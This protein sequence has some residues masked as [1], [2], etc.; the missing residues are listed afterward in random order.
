MLYSY[1]KDDNIQ[2]GVF[3]GLFK[4][5]TSVF[6]FI[7]LISVLS[8]N[9]YC[10][11]N[12]V[13]EDKTLSPY[14]LVEGG[15]GEEFPL[16]DTNV[17]VNINGIIAEIYVTQTYENN[18][19]EAVNATYVFPASTKVSVHGMKMTI[20]DKVVRAKI[21]E[22]EIAKKE[23]EA[24]KNEGKS[25]SLLEEQ[26][27]NVFTMNVANIMPKDV[28]N[29]ELHYTE[30]ITPSDG[31]Y[32]FVYPTVVG[33]RYSNKSAGSGNDWVQSPYIKNPKDLNTKFNI[34]VGISTALPLSEVVSMSHKVNIEYVDKS[35]AKIKLV[36]PEEFSG[37]RDYILDYKLSEKEVQSGIMTYKGEKENFF[38]L[39]IQPPERVEEKDITN[40]EYIFVIDISGSMYGYP[41][42]TAKALLKNLTANLKKTDKFNVI[43]FAGSSQKM[44]PYSLPATEENLK[45][46]IQLIDSEE[47]GGG[48]ELLPALESA[49]NTKRDNKYSRSIVVVTDGYVDVEKEVFDL[50]TKNSHK[51]NFFS[52]GIGESVNRYLIEG[53]AKSGHGEPFIVT[54]QEGANEVAESFRKYIESPVLTDIN[55]KYHDFGVYDIEP[56]N[57]PDLFAQRPIVVIGKWKGDLKGTIEISGKTSKGNYIQ[58]I[59]VSQIEALEENGAI[60]YLWA[61]ERVQRLGYANLNNDNKDVQAEITKLGLDYSMLT[62]YTSFVAVLDTVRNNTG[63]SKDVKQPLPLPLHVSDLAVGGGYSSA[64]EPGIVILAVLLVLGFVLY[65]RRSS[66][67][68]IDVL[69]KNVK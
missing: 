49:L 21:K 47:G 29:I 33:P 53:I 28:V 16:K 20:G 42:D 59:E 67:A 6:L 27:P 48:T 23:Y 44:S 18:G 68:R 19:K 60:P 26:R 39:T 15:G 66:K 46:A 35:T 31:K 43:L 7:F 37:N 2:G 9:S 65:S 56:L 1:I 61:R 3:V 30:L 11:Q 63:A 58:K 5:V 8:V 36:N 22:K 41:L 17:S 38:L 50:I 14:F 51:T 62:P 40:R 64:D 34:N 57:I 55:V 24:A 10:D 32:Q 13:N 52:F 12:G 25:A 69:G 54:Q 4:K 45:K